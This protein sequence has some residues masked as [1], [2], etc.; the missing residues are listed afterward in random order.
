M[1]LVQTSE[2]TIR[3]VNIKKMIVGLMFET[4]V[5]IDQLN[6]GL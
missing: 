5:D 6:K 4:S 3:I 1:I 2:G